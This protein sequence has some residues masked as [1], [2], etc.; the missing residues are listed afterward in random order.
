M[1]NRAYFQVSYDYIKNVILL[2]FVFFFIFKI[3]LVFI[4]FNMIPKTSFKI[5]LRLALD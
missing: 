1:Q 5:A 4:R 3:M 2:F